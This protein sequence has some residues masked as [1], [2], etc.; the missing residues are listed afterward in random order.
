MEIRCNPKKN[1]HS[2]FFI[3]KHKKERSQGGF[4]LGSV[5]AGSS[6]FT[7]SGFLTN[8][9]KT[10]LRKCLNLSNISSLTSIDHNNDR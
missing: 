8:L 7:K 10:S 6:N 9:E 1:D 5:L 2:K 4:S 3:F